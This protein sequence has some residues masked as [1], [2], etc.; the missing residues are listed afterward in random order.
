MIVRV[1]LARYKPEAGGRSKQANIELGLRL[2]RALKDEIPSVRN[3]EIGTNILP[4][5]GGYDT[6]FSAEFDDLDGAK[7]AFTHPAHDRMAEFLAEVTE[8]RQSVTYEVA[9]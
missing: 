7:A 6:A 9:R 2:A 1:S 8:A 3:I 4:Q 5:P